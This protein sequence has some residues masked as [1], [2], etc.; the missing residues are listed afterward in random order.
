[1]ILRP[2]DDKCFILK[3]NNIEIRNTTGLELLGL[4][5][6]HKLKFYAH[7]DKLCKT[8]RFE[9]QALRRIK[10][11]LTLEQAKLL[12]NSFVNTQFGY[13]P[14]I[15]MFTSKNSM[16][17]VNEIHRR[18]LRL[19]Y[20]D[21][22]SIYEELLVSYN[23]TS[24]HQKHLR[25]LAIEV[26]KSLTNLNPEFMWPFFKNKSIPYNS[27]NGNICILLPARSSH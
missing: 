21:C 20:D 22:N 27:R 9:L 10:T 2:S 24:I 25:H 8:A 17:K 13:A 16:L 15:W 11:F 12:V 18:T 1:M 7:I 6:D 14:L 3:I 26:Y 19:V 5:I 4:T 23:D